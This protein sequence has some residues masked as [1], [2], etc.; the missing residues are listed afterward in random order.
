MRQV[1][2]LYSIEVK[3]DANY[4]PSSATRP[5]NAARTARSSTSDDLTAELTVLTDFGQSLAAEP[6]RKS[7]QVHGLH[8]VFPTPV[9]SASSTTPGPSGRRVT[10]GASL[11]RDSTA[12]SRPPQ[13]RSGDPSQ[14]AAHGPSA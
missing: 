10:S 7:N 9:W 4:P 5:D 14:G 11:I 13:A 6:T 12:G 8:N 2:A 3:T 1:A